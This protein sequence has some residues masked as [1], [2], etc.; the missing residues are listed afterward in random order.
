MRGQAW[1][2]RKVP[3]FPTRQVR[4]GRK[5]PMTEPGRNTK[6]RCVVKEAALEAAWLPTGMVGN[7]EDEQAG[8]A[9]CRSTLGMSSALQNARRSLA[10]R[11]WRTAAAPASSLIRGSIAS[12]PSRSSLSVMLP[13]R[14]EVSSSSWP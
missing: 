12:S 14:L 5:E 8:D 9:S 1:I 11:I 6:G 3:S 13:Y 10:D 4:E 7:M 2:L